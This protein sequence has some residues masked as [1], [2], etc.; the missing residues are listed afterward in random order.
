MTAR[1]AL[2]GSQ[3]PDPSAQLDHRARL[4]F[5]VL[6]G[7]RARMVMMDCP[8]CRERRGLLVL[9]AC[10]VRPALALLVRMGRKVLKASPYR[11]R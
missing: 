1:K 7:M 4:A 10:K 3:S 9:Q 5:K 6:L 8:V 11:G 2:R